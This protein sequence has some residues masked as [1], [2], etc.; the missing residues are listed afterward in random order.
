MFVTLAS[1]A[2]ENF[3][4]ANYIFTKG[5]CYL[6]LY[7][8]RIVNYPIFVNKTFGEIFIQR[9]VQILHSDMV[10]VLKFLNV[11]IPTNSMMFKDVQNLVELCHLMMGKYL[12]TSSN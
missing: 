12:N 6:S 1:K 8:N 2:I 4:V 3:L 11:S 7:L 5:K 10:R 9:G